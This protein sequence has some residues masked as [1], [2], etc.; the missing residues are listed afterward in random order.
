MYRI[1]T[2]IL[3]FI[4]MLVQRKAS[5]SKNIEWVKKRCKEDDL[6]DPHLQKWA[7][8]CQA[9]EV[10]NIPVRRAGIQSMDV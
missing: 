7:C 8:V 9:G 1:N 6:F 4:G 5:S 10:G 2:L 3:V